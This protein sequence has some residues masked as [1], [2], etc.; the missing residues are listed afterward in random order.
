MSTAP[1]LLLALDFTGTFAFALNG[2][3]TAVRAARL[4]IVGV[5]TLGM[6]TALGGGIMRDVLIGAVPPTAFQQWP[7]LALA[8]GGGLVAFALSQ[9][10]DRLETPINVLDAVG[11]ST[12]AVIGASTALE[13]GLDVTP[14]ILLGGV[15]AVGGGTIRDTLVRRVP[16]VLQS[17]LYAIPALIGAAVT[18][19]TIRADIYGVWA[20]L[21]AVGVCFVIRMLGVHFGLQAPVPPAHRDGNA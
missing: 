3:L 17:D 10:L 4:D 5:V 11:L 9:W 6:I 15:T 1:P 8:G 20:A 18:V 13:A 21:A 19:V 7:Y 14:A 2:A 16:S 12:F